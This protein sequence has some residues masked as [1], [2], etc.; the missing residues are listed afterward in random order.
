MPIVKLKKFISY[1]VF[2]IFCLAMPISVFGATIKNDNYPRLANLFFRWDITESEARA[3]V[4]WDMLI[5][6]MEAQKQS[7]QNLKLIKKLNPQIKILAYLAPQEIR[8]DSGTLNGTLRQNLFQKIKENWWL[9]NDKGEKSAWWPGNPLINI[10]AETELARGERFAD[11][12]SDFLRDEIMQSGY[13]DGIFFDN[14]WDNLNFMTDFGFDLN[15]DGKAESMEFINQKWREGMAD[16]LQKTR[17]KIGSGYLLV[18]NG[19]IFYN[20]Y[21]NGVLFEHFPKYG[22]TETMKKYSGISKNGVVPSFGVINSNVN[23]SGRKS[24]Y[25]KMRFGLASS[26]LFDG[27]FSFDN[28]DKSHHEIWWYDEYETSLGEPLASAKKIVD[29]ENFSLSEGVWRR[30]FSRGLVIVNSTNKEQKISLNGDYEKIF[31]NQDSQINSGGFVQELIMR[32]NDGLLLLKPI[33]RVQKGAYENGSFVRAFG[34]SGKLTRNG[35]FSYRDSL[36]GGS[37][38]VELTTGFVAGV[39]NEVRVYD[40][41]GV[42]LKKFFPFGREYQDKINL[43]VADLSGNGDLEIVVAREKFSSDVKIFDF[44]GEE[45]SA[46][47]K[48]YAENFQGGVDLA[49]CDL[50][51]DGQMEIVTGAGFGGGPH[52]RIFE[53]NG[54]LFDSGFFAFDR[55]WR[56]GVNVACGDADND[57]QMEIIAGSGLGN[58]A[59]IKIFDFRNRKVKVEFSPYNE[60]Y[61]RGAEISFG[62]IDND[63]SGEIIFSAKNIF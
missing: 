39:D 14:V 59:K 47:F 4:K 27:F 8:G 15:S 34:G 6:D 36:P 45:D 38:I 42:L 35:F 20:K 49:L 33:D 22:W 3:L 63:G 53:F 57:G 41:Q 37:K 1:S 11:V 9:K 40:K 58:S 31:G 16:I 46:S 44:Y 52:I 56:N 51:G 62:D 28:G 7:P 18:G 25:Q 13:W 30:D 61:R 32:P 12:F 21:L 43:A 26:L 24:D 2:L 17:A 55:S 29:G 5:I 10:T 60:N 19:G 23:N 48:A 54:K 50:N